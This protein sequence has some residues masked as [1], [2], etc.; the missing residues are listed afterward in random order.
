MGKKLELKGKRFGRWTVLEEVSKNI[1]RQTM[2][3]C[4]CD[5]GNKAEVIGGNLI[6]GTSMSCGCFKNEV[7]SKRSK[8]KNNPMYGKKGKDSPSFGIPLTQEHKDNISMANKG[9]KQP[10]LAG[11]NH[12]IY[13]RNRNLM[14]KNIAL[15]DTYGHQL[16]QF[17]FEEVRT[18]MVLIDGVVYKSLQVRCNNSDCKKWFVPKRTQVIHRLQ[19]FKGYRTGQHNFY[20]NYLCKNTCS[21]YHKVTY[22]EGEN[23]N[24]KELLYTSKEYQLYRNIVLE[25]ENY[26]CEYCDKS[27]TDVHHEKPKKTDPM[28]A[29]DTDYGHACC[30]ECHYK[31]GHK[32]GTE[33]STGALA[34]KIC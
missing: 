24:K 15:Y 28:L 33:C 4:I 34:R 7:T 10:V 19:V 11:S 13:Y 29:L 2:W 31:Y 8:G 1:H 20:C 12:D 27:A 5:C 3:L 32:K 23:P 22:R 25:R 9:R 17:N 6:A 30:K 14:R 18:H 21:T 16:K 26:I